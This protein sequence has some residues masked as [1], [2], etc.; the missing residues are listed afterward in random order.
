MKWALIGVGHIGTAILEGWIKTG[1]RAED[2]YISVSTR[3]KEDSLQEKYGVSILQEASQLA[4]CDLVLFAVKPQDLPQ[5]AANYAPYIL[6]TTLIVSVAAG[7]DLSSLRLMLGKTGPSSD[8]YPI[9]RV[10][11]NLPSK[12]GAGVSVMVANEHVSQEQLDQAK[13]IFLNLGL[14][15]ELPEENFA[16]VTALSGS[17]PAFVAVFIE[18]LAD[19]AVYAG[20]HSEAAN[21]LAAQTLLGTAKLL[22]ESKTP[23]AILK[24]Q[25]CTAAGTSIYGIRALEKSGFRASVFDA[26]IAAS[27]RTEALAAEAAENIV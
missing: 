27:E 15:M 12:V 20:L 5:I 17:G 11:P 18:A 23:P 13:S 16:A 1:Y 9:L 25:V 3:E 8:E 24:N 19:A 10:L 7:I 21:T 14:V 26:V 4:D 22:L 6:S 2:V